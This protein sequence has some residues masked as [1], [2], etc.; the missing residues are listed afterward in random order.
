MVGR[1]KRGRGGSEK[2]KST[3]VKGEGPFLSGSIPSPFLSFFPTPRVRGFAL[4]H[5]EF[6]NNLL[7]KEETGGF[8]RLD[9]FV[10]TRKKI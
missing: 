4:L 7:R 3:R 9:F 1:R 10:L 2:R 6:Q 5:S 8:H